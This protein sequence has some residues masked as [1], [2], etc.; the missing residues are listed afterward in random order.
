LPSPLYLLLNF[1]VALIWPCQAALSGLVSLYLT[2]TVERNEPLTLLFRRLTLG[3]IY[4]VTFLATLPLALAAI[5]IRCVLSLARKPYQYSVCHKEHTAAEEDLLE[6]TLSGPGLKE[7]CFGIAT[8]NVC[9]LPE[10]LARINNLSHAGKRARSIGERIV[11]DQ[12]FYGGVPKSILGMSENAESYSS[13]N[14][15]WQSWP[16]GQKQGF[17]GGLTSHFP[18]LDFLCMQEVFDWN[19]NRT[20][21]QELHKVNH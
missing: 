1:I 11:V 18:R 15:M 3:P 20:L 14:H 5:V 19:Y 6:K 12:F 8:A 17:T 7:H 2:T 10:F 13:K 16:G 4:A 21:R 9:L